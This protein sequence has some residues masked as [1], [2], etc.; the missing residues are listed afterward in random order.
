[1]S[2]G[3]EDVRKTP[4][5]PDLERLLHDLRGPLNAAVMHVEVLKRLIDDPTARTSLQSI[6]GELERLTAMLPVAF[7][8]SAIELGPVRPVL[9]RAVVQSAVDESRRKP[10]HVEP[11]TWPEV[12]GDER[13]LVRAM[14]QLLDNAFDATPDGR[15]VRVRV[16]AGAGDTVTLAV[17]DGGAGFKT[18]NPNAVIKLMASTKPGHLGVGLLVVQRIARLHGGGI[19][20]ETR[21]EGGVARLTLRVRR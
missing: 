14:R 5:P 10:V 11:G 13:L 12:E 19:T 16:E 6:Q 21:P 9:L 7:G 3:A 18:R 17:E 2:S 8:V 1:M 15:D 4:L 20:F